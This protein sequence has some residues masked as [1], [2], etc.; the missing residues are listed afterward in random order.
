MKPPPHETD[1]GLRLP[2]LAGP[3]ITS[4]ISQIFLRF[5]MELPSWTSE[6]VYKAIEVLLLFAE[7]YLRSFSITE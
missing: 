4:I 6:I 3:V 2:R 5:A 1:S 7:Y